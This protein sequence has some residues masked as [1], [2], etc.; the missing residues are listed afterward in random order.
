EGCFRCE[1]T[2]GAGAEEL[3]DGCGA[4]HTLLELC[5]RGDGAGGTLG[6]D[7]EGAL[8][9]RSWRGLSGEQVDRQVKERAA[10]RRRNC[11]WNI[12]SHG[13]LPRRPQLI[14]VCVWPRP[15]PRPGRL[16]RARRRRT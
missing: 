16:R 14:A 11:D 8:R 2:G 4:S 1:V 13:C 7:E 9:A 10:D 6:A 5:I 3:T 12:G 15:S